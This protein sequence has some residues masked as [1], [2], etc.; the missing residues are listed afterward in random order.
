MFFLITD[1]RRHDAIAKAT[2]SSAELN[3]TYLQKFEFFINVTCKI[4]FRFFVSK[5]SKQMQW[6]DLMG[7]EKHVVLDKINLPE[8]FPDLPNVQ[9]IQKLWKDFKQLYGIL[10]QLTLSLIA[11]LIHCIL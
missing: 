7:P 11:Q 3:S 8:V 6:R 5:E 1:I 10:Q 9:E 2:I 4:P